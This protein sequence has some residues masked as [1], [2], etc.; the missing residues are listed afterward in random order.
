MLLS[1]SLSNDGVCAQRDVYGLNHV[2]NN[3]R[4]RIRVQTQIRF[5]A[6]FTLDVNKSFTCEVGLFL[7][8][9]KNALSL[10]TNLEL[11]TADSGIP[12][13]AACLPS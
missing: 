5:R 8:V 4:M 12:A 10:Q 2:M 9:I 6:V 1:K 11:P 7:Q 3:S 13:A